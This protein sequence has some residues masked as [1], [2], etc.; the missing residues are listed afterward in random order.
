MG[1]NMQDRAGQ[2]ALACSIKTV[3]SLMKIFAGF[4]HI[5]PL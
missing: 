2:R 4:C 5:P 3:F 1:F